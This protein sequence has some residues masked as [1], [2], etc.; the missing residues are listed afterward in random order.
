MILVVVAQTTDVFSYKISVK[1]TSFDYHIKQ[2]TIPFLS[3][4]AS[5]CSIS[6]RLRGLFNNFTIEIELQL[7]SHFRHSGNITKEVFN[8]CRMTIYVCIR[9]NNIYK[10]LQDLQLLFSLICNRRHIIKKI[11]VGYCG[12]LPIFIQF[13]NFR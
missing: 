13:L 10:Y 2:L 3:I 9:W 1:K 6:F 11:Y 5:A 7:I 12:L 4:N 8:Y